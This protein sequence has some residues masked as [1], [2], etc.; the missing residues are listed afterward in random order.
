MIDYSIKE[1]YLC[2]GWIFKGTIKSKTQIP[3]SIIHTDDFAIRV[4]NPV[5]FYS[6]TIMNIPSSD[7]SDVEISVNDAMLKDLGFDASPEEAEKKIA[8]NLIK[9][10]GLAYFIDSTTIII[11]LLPS[12]VFSSDTAEETESDGYD[13][14]QITVTFRLNDVLESIKLDCG[15]LPSIRRS[16][17]FTVYKKQSGSDDPVFPDDEARVINPEDKDINCSG[18]DFNKHFKYEHINDYAISQSANFN[19]N[20][21]VDGLYIG[22]WVNP[23][24]TP[25]YEA[26]AVVFMPINEYTLELSSYLYDPYRDYKLSA[27]CTLSD[28]TQSTEEMFELIPNETQIDQ[29]ADLFSQISGG[30]SARYRTATATQAICPDPKESIQYQLRLECIVSNPDE[31]ED[32]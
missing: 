20:E 27:N 5:S 13:M 1:E 17:N 7:N 25:I 10:G 3:T 14:A 12:Y 29:Y 15:I 19:Y 18:Y 21:T 6:K 22:D 32:E 16:K 24:S 31:G 26:S 30:Y 23:D 11:Y 2:N 8:A 28:W 4:I 9:N